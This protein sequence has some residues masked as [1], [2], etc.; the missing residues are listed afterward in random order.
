MRELPD[1]LAGPKVAPQRR[2]GPR[3][4]LGAEAGRA[5]RAGPRR[6]PACRS[7]RSC[8]TRPPPR[9]GLKPGDV[10]TTLDGRWTTSVADT[11][12]A[13]AG[14]A[15]G[16]DVAVV[17]LRDGQE[18]TLTVRPAGRDLTEDRG[19]AM[20]ASQ[21]MAKDEPSTSVRLSRNSLLAPARRHPL[22]RV[23]DGAGERAGA[24]RACWPWRGGARREG[25]SPLV[26]HGPSGVGKSRLLAGLVAECLQRRPGSAVAHLEAE[27]FAAACAEAAGQRGGWAELRERFRRLDLFVLEDLHALERAPLALAELAHTLDALDDAGAGVAVSARVGAGP[28]VGLAAAA[29]QPPGRGP[30]GPG[31]SARAWPRAGGTCSTAPGPRGLAL[32][33]EAVE[34][35][36]EAGDGY[37]TLDGWLARLALAGPA[38]AAG[39]STGALV[40][41]LLAEEDAV[42]T[43]GHDRRGRPRRRRAVRRPARRP[44][45]HTRRPAIVEPGTWRCTWPATSTGQSFQAIGTYFGGR[46][47]ATVRHACRA[48]AARARRRPRPGR[49]RRRPAPPLAVRR[50]PG[51]DPGLL[52]PPALCPAHLARSGV[53][54]HRR[55]P[56]RGRINGGHVRLRRRC[57]GDGRRRLGYPAGVR[58]RG[59]GRVVSTTDQR[60]VLTCGM[61]DRP[62]MRMRQRAQEHAIL[63]APASPKLRRRPLAPAVEIPIECHALIASLLPMRL[64]IERR[65]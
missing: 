9:A 14:V 1:R 47:P 62:M 4:A 5:G 19:T 42:A 15:P 25:L 61:S 40:A 21:A 64:P 35:L 45:R 17:I 34:A 63:E 12:A 51:R 33:A 13:A 24:A 41:P 44:P 56:G 46:D 59:H 22:G 11:Y 48:A 20:G 65:S 43:A 8:P 53:V 50:A 60:R 26:V 28:V 52:R 6:R 57:D 37:R 55:R 39:R 29:G 7:A 30:G 49:R 27:A 32:S 3:R 10:L 38:S 18:Q 36:A 31:R 16:R 58:G 23:R 54:R 2:A